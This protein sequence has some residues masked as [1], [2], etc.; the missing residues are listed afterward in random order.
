M[1]NSLRRGLVGKWLRQERLSRR[2]QSHHSVPHLDRRELERR[3]L[4][5]R[6]IGSTRKQNLK[7]WKVNYYII[8]KYKT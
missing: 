5:Q 2:V 1:Q 3:L 6:L 8:L 7:I 4:L